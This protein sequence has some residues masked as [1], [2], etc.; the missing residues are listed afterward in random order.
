MIE[1][2]PPG[3]L[4]PVQGSSSR[5]NNSGSYG[6][7]STAL[8]SSMLSQQSSELPHHVPSL[9]VSRPSNGHGLKPVAR[10]HSGIVHGSDGN[11]DSATR[12]FTSGTWTVTSSALG[13]DQSLQS[14]SVIDGSSLRPDSHVQD[15]PNQAALA[16]Q[17]S[18]GN[19]IRDNGSQD[20]DGA[21]SHRSLGTRQVPHEVVIIDD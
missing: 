4:L 17:L 21:H 3:D 10:S 6:F 19:M 1:K 11:N 5:L 7:R 15:A 14:I 20:P 18:D 9:Q 12:G 13:G 8:S 2:L 16:R